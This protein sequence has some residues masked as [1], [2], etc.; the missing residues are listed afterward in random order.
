MEDITIT[1]EHIEL[2]IGH[3]RNVV[4]D[5][6][7]VRFK[8]KEK[9]KFGPLG[10]MYYLLPDNTIIYHDNPGALPGLSAHIY[11]H[12]GSWKDLQ[13]MEGVKPNTWQKDPNGHEWGVLGLSYEAP[14]ER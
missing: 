5:G 10:L 11:T 3:H 8:A 9:G 2:A 7:T 1:A 6:N 13:K 12:L 4:R 14:K